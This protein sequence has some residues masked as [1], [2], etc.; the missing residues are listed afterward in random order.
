M[1]CTVCKT[2]WC[3]LCGQDISLKT[4][5]NDVDT[6]YSPTNIR[7][8]PGSQFTNGT[9][10]CVLLSTH[11]LVLYPYHLLPY[12]INTPLGNGDFMWL[13]RLTSVIWWLVFA[14]VILAT[15]LG[16]CSVLLAFNLATLCCFCCCCGNCCR[17]QPE[18]LQAMIFG[19]PLFLALLVMT[20]LWA[21]IGLV[22]TTVPLYIYFSPFNL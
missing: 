17:I 22:E 11:N 19:P 6:H 1:V 3:W 16:Y 5:G 21:V 14:V 8:C 9:P 20:L 15:T 10:T 18:A 12:I 4:T 7:G 2:D 13:D